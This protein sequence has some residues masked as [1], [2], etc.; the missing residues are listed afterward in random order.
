M[1]KNVIVVGMPRSGTSMLAAVFARKGFFVAEDVEEELREPDRANPDGYW[2]ARSLVDRNV[3][4]LAA[5]GFPHHNTWLFDAIPPVQ[6]SRL[7][8]LDPLPEHRHFAESYQ[9]H[10]PWIWKDPRLCYTLRYWWPLLDHAGTRVLLIKRSHEAIFRSFVRLGWRDETEEARADVIRR[11]D[12]HLSAAEQ[13]LS[14]L[15]IPHLVLSYEAF[16]KDGPRI[17]RQLGELLEADFTPSDLG[18]E[19]RY[20]HSSVP[21]RALF[22]LERLAMSLPS[23]V[24]RAVR[25]CAPSSWLGR[26]F[27]GMEP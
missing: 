13:A 14:S 25:T 19:K 1:A 6:A 15:Q 4:V 17:A 7:A 27:P 8:D 9:Q 11:I 26:V 23:P 3:E 21:G 10:A 18:F 2:E 16:S 24:R 20:D 22:M 5:A 12:D